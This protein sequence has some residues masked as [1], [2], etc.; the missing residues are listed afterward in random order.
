M[1]S[2]IYS[3]AETIA[4]VNRLLNSAY[5][6]QYGADNEAMTQYAHS[7][8]AAQQAI[9]ENADEDTIIAAFLHDIGHMLLTKPDTWDEKSN[10][11]DEQ[12]E[13]VGYHWLVSHGFS[14]KVCRLV[15]GHVEAKRY[16]TYADSSYANRLSYQSKMTL[17]GQGG[18]MSKEEADKFKESEWFETKLKM[19]L[20]DEG[21]KL[22]PDEW[23][24]KGT[25]T[26][27]FSEMIL[28]HLNYQIN[29]KLATQ[30]EI[31]RRPSQNVTV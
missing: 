10:P 2:I 3:P 27:Y 17:I 24:E 6:T 25:E 8:Q 30:P 14:E 7:I 5:S 20:W 22:G 28:R 16:L 12:H 13:W 31:Q 1:P 29:N 21:A 19:R 23:Q 18:P 4:E 26:E 9:Q 15:L 11:Q